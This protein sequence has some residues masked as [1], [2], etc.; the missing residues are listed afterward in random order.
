MGASKLLI[1]SRADRETSKTE[2][3]SEELKL[4]LTTS[5]GNL[6]QG[7]TTLTVGGVFF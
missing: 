7:L 3:S 2:V 5:V 4:D 1:S 6:L